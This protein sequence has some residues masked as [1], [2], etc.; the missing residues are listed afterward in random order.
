MG[1]RSQVTCLRAH[2]VSKHEN[3]P[4]RSVLKAR[5]RAALLKLK[6]VVSDKKEGHSLEASVRAHH[7][8]SSDSTTYR[9]RPVACKRPYLSQRLGTIHRKWH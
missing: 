5:V 1:L 2:E 3:N 6:Y 7:A 9:D 4:E 8:S